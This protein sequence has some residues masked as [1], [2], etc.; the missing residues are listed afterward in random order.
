MME[1]RRQKPGQYVARYT[2]RFS[3]YR[4]ELGMWA[5]FDSEQ[6]KDEGLVGEYGTLDQ[7]KRALS[8]IQAAERREQ[9]TKQ[10]AMQAEYRAA[11]K[12]KEEA[13]REERLATTPNL[14]NTG[15]FAQVTITKSEALKLLQSLANIAD[16]DDTV[17]LFIR[18]SEVYAL[19][20]EPGRRERLD[21]SVGSGGWT[22][23]RAQIVDSMI[24]PDEAEAQTA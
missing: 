10:S 3:I 24:V 2:N 15:V 22:I 20:S 6:T 9:Q 18:S 23:A 7:A 12:A 19:A 5:A 21:I 16:D 4:T 11:A 14:R 1:F 13:E 17:E 8:Q